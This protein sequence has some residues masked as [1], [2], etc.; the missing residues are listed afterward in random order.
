MASRATKRKAISDKAE[1][2]GPEDA[3]CDFDA[4]PVGTD[5][6]EAADSQSS[7]RRRKAL[8]STSVVVDWLLRSRTI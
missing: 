6:A 4:A 2:E 5:S 7:R 1:V 8:T 3:D